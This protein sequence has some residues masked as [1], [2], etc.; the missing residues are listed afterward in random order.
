MRAACAAEKRW[1]DVLEGAVLVRERIYKHQSPKGREYTR[2]RPPRRERGEERQRESSS[3]CR[4]PRRDCCIV[5][6]EALVLVKRAASGRAARP[7]EVKVEKEQVKVKAAEGDRC[8]VAIAGNEYHTGK[9][10]SQPNVVNYSSCHTICHCRDICRE[11]MSESVK[12]DERGKNSDYL[13]N[14]Y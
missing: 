5:G 12:W 9:S 10:L 13:T 14:D 7:P 2:N 6:N 4:H 8:T 11:K 1:R 3:L